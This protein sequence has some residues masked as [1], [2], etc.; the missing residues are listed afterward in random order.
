MMT[1][2]VFCGK[3]GRYLLMITAPCESN[4][5]HQLFSH[6]SQFFW[7]FVAIHTYVCLASMSLLYLSVL[8]TMSLLDGTILVEL[9]T[10][11]LAWGVQGYGPAILTIG[12]AILALSVASA[13]M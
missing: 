7:A 13:P 1:I 9:A 3:A 4:L 5:D 10:R 2:V 12:G 6:R 8:G 11:M